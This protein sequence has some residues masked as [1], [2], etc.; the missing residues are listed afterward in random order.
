MLLT[1]NSPLAIALIA[2]VG[3]VIKDML[4]RHASRL[5]SKRRAYKKKI[6]FEITTDYLKKLFDQQDGKCF[7]SGLPMTVADDKKY[8]ISV[9]RIDSSKGYTKDNVVLAAFIVNTMK[10]DL[11]LEDFKEIVNVLAG[12]FVEDSER[13]GHVRGCLL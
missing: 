10:N 9:D 3:L 11:S 1:L 4:S 2:I 5:E 6:P 7:Y 12:R 8:S 13:D